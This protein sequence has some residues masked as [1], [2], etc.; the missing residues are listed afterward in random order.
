M[1]MNYSPE[2]ESGAVKLEYKSHSLL[3]LCL[4]RPSRCAGKDVVDKISSMLKKVRSLSY[5]VVITGD[6]NIHYDDPSELQTSRLLQMLVTNQLDQHVTDATHVGGHTVDIIITNSRVNILDV[7]VQPPSVSDH[8]LAVWSY[9]ERPTTK[10]KQVRSS[11]VCTSVCPS[12]C[13]TPILYL[14]DLT[15]LKTFLTI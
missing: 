11:G 10:S 8:S 6:I 12:V 9:Q 14:N 1:Q 7:D 13:H 2:L 3:V 4:Y 5:P 15:Y